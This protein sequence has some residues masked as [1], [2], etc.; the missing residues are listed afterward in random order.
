VAPLRR[1]TTSDGTLLSGELPV[2][3]AG[4]TISSGTQAVDIDATD[5]MAASWIDSDDVVMFE[6]STPAGV[7]LGEFPVG[8]GSGRT[9]VAALGDNHAVV[10]LTDGDGWGDGVVLRCVLFTDDFESGDE[11]AWA[12]AVP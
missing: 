7:S 12:A 11:A 10:A 8:V 1:R 5:E 3:D 9:A 6:R 4:E 2:D